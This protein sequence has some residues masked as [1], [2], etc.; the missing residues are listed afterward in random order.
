MATTLVLYTDFPVIQELSGAG[1]EE[2]ARVP[3]TV[4][5]ELHEDLVESCTPGDVVTVLGLC[6]VISTDSKPGLLSL[7]PSCTL[8]T[9]REWHESLG[10]QRIQLSDVELVTMCCYV[11]RCCKQV[12][13]RKNR[14][15]EVQKGELPVPAVSRSN[16]LEDQ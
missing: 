5:V 11:H 2:A 3:R 9:R 8:L 14:R 15:R 1:G 13:E 16:I 12:S 6:K 10:I 7:P 4:E